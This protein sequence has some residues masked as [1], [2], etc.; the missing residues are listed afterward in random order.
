MPVGE[1]SGAI[2]AHSQRLADRVLKKG[3]HLTAVDI[4]ALAASGLSEVTVARLGA[5][6]VH[7]DV[8]AAALAQQVGGAGVRVDKADTGRANMF[9]EVD[10]LVEVD[11]ASVNAL[12]AV[13]PGLTL[14]TLHAYKRVAAGRMVGTV[15]IIPF[16]VRRASLDAALGHVPR[17]ILRWRRGRS[18][19]WR[20]SRPCSRH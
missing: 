10:G 8:A 18:G 5:D 4:E 6:D 13:D 7:E 15:K 16:A 9:A 17:P 14:A 2:L 12:N 11:A 19:V 20:L 3:H 1:A